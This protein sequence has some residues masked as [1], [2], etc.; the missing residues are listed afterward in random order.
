MIVNYF[1][2]EEY[3]KNNKNKSGLKPYKSVCPPHFYNR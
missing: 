3:Q 2:S 1:N